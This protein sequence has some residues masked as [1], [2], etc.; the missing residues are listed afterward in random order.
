MQ[1]QVPHIATAG[2]IE[3]YLDADA[4]TEIRANHEQACRELHERCLGIARRR[5]ELDADEA[6]AL[7]EAYELQVWRAY[8]MPTL[9]AYLEHVLGYTPRMSEERMRVAREL[10]DL[11]HTRASLRAGLAWTK[12][13]E[14]AASRR[15][16]P[17]SRGSTR[18]ETSTAGRSR[19]S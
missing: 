12:V 14:S 11:P 4:Q 8:A 2:C 15:A 9:E 18:R 13:R 6:D 3:R 17:S 1:E 16:T 5:G 19:T 10:Q 7:C